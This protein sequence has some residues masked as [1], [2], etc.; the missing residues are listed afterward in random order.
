MAI[1]EEPG[2]FIATPDESPSGP[3]GEPITVT[4]TPS[5]PPTG[6]KPNLP[7]PNPTWEAVGVNLYKVPAGSHTLIVGPNI[8]NDDFEIKAQWGPDASGA[9][10]GAQIAA[11]IIA[12]EHEDARFAAKMELERQQL[13][14]KQMSDAA[15]RELRAAQLEADAAYRRGDL[16][17]RAQAEE[18]MTAAQEAANSINEKKLQLDIAAAQTQRSELLAKLAANPRD[19]VQYFH[20]VRPDLGGT[21]LDPK[22]T[23]V[24]GPQAGPAEILA[25]HPGVKELLGLQEERFGLGQTPSA[26]MLRKAG[27]TQV[28]VAQSVASAGGISNE[29]FADLVRKANPT[30]SINQPYVEGA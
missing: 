12:Q 28:G 7:T 20:M 11:T 9:A 14:A 13:E 16:Q 2:G 30:K 27:P 25:A 10:S 26:Q 19:T 29:E 23:I 4:P 24:G 8:Y 5:K 3:T 18:R 22:G 15:D 6:G 1:T 17:L 21:I